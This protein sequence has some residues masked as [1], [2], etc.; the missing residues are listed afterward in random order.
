VIIVCVLAIAAGLRLCGGKGDDVDSSRATETR[1]ITPE[2]ILQLA[3]G[4]KP[5][6]LRTTRD[7]IPGGLS[8]A[9]APMLIDWEESMLEGGDAF[10]IVHLVNYGGNPIEGTTELH[11]V[12]IPLDGVERV[13]WV[14]VPLG[15]G[16]KRAAIHHGQLRFVFRPDRPVTLVNLAA[17]DAG[18]DTRLYDLVFSWE[19]W[20]APGV[21]YDVMKGMDPTRY[22]LSLRAYAGAQRFLEDAL[23]KRDWYATT[24]RLPGGREGLSEVLKVTLAL[25]DGIARHTISEQFA[26]SMD[27]WLA[28]APVDD[29][30][31][32]AAQWRELEALAAPVDAVSDP[33]LN[34]P[35]EERTYQTVLRSCASVAYYSVLVAVERLADRGLDDGVEV[36][37]LDRPHLGG[38]EP[39][40]EELA[41]ANLGGI[42]K[43]APKA[44]IWLRSHPY[45]LPDKI[46]GRL[47]AAGLVQHEHGKPV[48]AH[49]S[50]SGTT[51]YGTLAAN[52]IR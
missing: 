22:A 20:R 41:T 18:G 6:R 7:V 50:L 13:E 14:L 38:D 15:R 24:L 3:E 33:R 4:D 2:Q 31:E 1:T 12:K 28:A 27:L 29:R 35:A 52:L 32:L 45:A 48:E 25:G 17:A 21:D 47:D 36:S 40:M 26:E 46:P 5:L 23:S 8:A 51:P 44:L 42:F 49:Y 37:H 11:S 39:W 43:R 30:D 16:G 19:A 34:P 10:A 9:M